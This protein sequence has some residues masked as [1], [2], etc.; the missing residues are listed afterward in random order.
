MGKK[1]Y[2]KKGKSIHFPLFPYTF[3]PFF[4]GQKWGWTPPP[5]K[6]YQYNNQYFKNIE[7]F[8]KKYSLILK[9]DFC[10]SYLNVKNRIIKKWAI[11][12][13]SI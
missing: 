5:H 1:V 12:L 10:K 11:V 9:H 7:L 3:F 6:L 4:H 8:Y 2:G 13:D